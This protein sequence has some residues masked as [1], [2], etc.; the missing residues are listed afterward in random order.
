MEIEKRDSR[1]KQILRFIILSTPLYYLV[2]M[3]NIEAQIRE[4][5]L[6][7]QFIT[8]DKPMRVSIEGKP[9]VFRRIRWFVM[10][11]GLLVEGFFLF[12]K[13][14][15][16][17][18]AGVF[19]FFSVITGP[20]LVLSAL[21]PKIKWNRAI[22]GTGEFNKTRELFILFVLCTIGVAVVFFSFLLF[23]RK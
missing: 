4:M 10:G 18:F 1:L 6:D 3:K 14:R 2:R 11:I 15:L 8:R 23:A 9:D 21:F 22:L 13:K 17:D 19:A 7:Y 5:G 16:D 20:I 12:G